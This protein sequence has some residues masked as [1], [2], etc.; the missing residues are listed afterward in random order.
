MI[1]IVSRFEIS[2]LVCSYSKTEVLEPL[3]IAPEISREKRITVDDDFHCLGHSVAP[4]GE[5]PICIKGIQSITEKAIMTPDN[6]RLDMDYERVAH[7][8]GI[9]KASKVGQVSAVEV[10]TIK[11]KSLSDYFR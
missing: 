7:L 2:F 11:W 6:Y 8:I 9:G 3:K 10:I 4:E 1:I 5:Y